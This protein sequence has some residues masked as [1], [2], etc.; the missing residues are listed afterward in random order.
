MDDGLG[1]LLTMK[2]MWAMEKQPRVANE[3]ED[4][5]WTTSNDNREQDNEGKERGGEKS[6]CGGDIR[7]HTMEDDC[8]SSKKGRCFLCPVQSDW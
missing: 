4:G 5:Q 3:T 6:R 1:P 7:E 8:L 2:W